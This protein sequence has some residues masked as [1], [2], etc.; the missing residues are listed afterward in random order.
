MRSNESYLG[1][2]NLEGDLGVVI[3]CIEFSLFPT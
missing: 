3:D 1:W 2:F